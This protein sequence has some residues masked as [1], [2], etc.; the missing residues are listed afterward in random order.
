M[1]RFAA[2][3]DYSAAVAAN[4]AAAAPCACA[5]SPPTALVR[6]HSFVCRLMA[7]LPSEKNSLVV[8]VG[9]LAAVF[10]IPYVAPFLKLERF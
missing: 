10:A 7:H 2:M 1:H 6:V 5:E 3:V 4:M 9:V 8:P